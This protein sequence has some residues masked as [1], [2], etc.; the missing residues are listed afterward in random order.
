MTLWDLDIRRCFRQGSSRFEL[1]VR[2]TSAVQRVV[3]FGPSGAGKTQTMR[4]LAGIV[5]P[6]AGRVVVAGRTLFD[7][8]S[9]I[10]LSPQARGL[11]VVFQ[12]YALFPHLTVTQNIA[13]ALH[14]RWRNPGRRVADT[15]VQT[16]IERL[17][18][19]DVAHHWPHQLSGGQRQRTALAR[20]LVNEPAALLL[21]EPFAALDKRLRQQ[22]RDDLLA[23]QQSLGL[24][25]LLI[26]H[27][28]DDVRVL[29]Q[30]VIHLDAGRVVGVS[31]A[32]GSTAPSA[33]MGL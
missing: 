15:R 2:F 31:D 11:G 16:W 29:G 28:E 20:A 26:T 1:D 25:L 33:S 17:R 21:D 9:G 23:L 4:M 19:H 22:L 10:C 7:T 24:P 14:R 13:F 30:Q 5:A 8:G 12:D 32:P 3:L 18:L 27:D 6:D